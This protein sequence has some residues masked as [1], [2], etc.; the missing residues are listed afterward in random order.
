MNR[1][2]L[3]QLVA[4]VQSFAAAQRS[5]AVLF[6]GHPTDPIPRALILDR[7][8]PVWAR[9]L[10]CYFRT[11]SDH[12]ATAGTAPSYSTIRKDLGIGSRGT[13]SAAI[14]ALRV[15]RW[16]TLLPASKERHQ[17]Y[18]LH[19]APLTWR[20]AIELDADYPARL[21][22]AIHSPRPQIRALARRLLEGSLETAEQEDP[23]T[24]S[25][26]LA[27]CLEAEDRAALGRYRIRGIV[28]P[29]SLPAAAPVS[30]ESEASVLDFHEEIL[31][32]SADLQPLAVLKLQAVPEKWRQAILDDLAVRVLERADGADPIRSPLAYLQWMVNEWQK[33]GELPLSGRGEELR[34]RQQALQAEQERQA[35]APR[36]EELRRLG[37]DLQH[38]QRLQSYQ[39]AQGVPNEWV[40]QQ[41]RQT[42]EQI[43]ALQSGEHHGVSCALEKSVGGPGHGWPPGSHCE[44][45]NDLTEDDSKFQ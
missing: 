41:L 16:I 23:R 8:L 22:E 28:E 26:R 31:G 24:E 12:P 38:F 14:C 40:N 36:Q 19:N 42:Q 30:S 11:R 35:D 21:E 4:Q 2:N 1:T 27:S 13:V 39:E 3:D 32:I 7:D 10:W 34:R 33:S 45:S 15:T 5:D 25:Y 20:Q 29:I 6:L 44:K 43:E 18:L 37:T 9:L 17:I